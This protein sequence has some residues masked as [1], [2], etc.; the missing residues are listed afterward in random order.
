MVSI[1]WLVSQLLLGV[2]YL[3]SRA[4]TPVAMAGHTSTLPW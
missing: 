1:G 4:R 3:K 2:P